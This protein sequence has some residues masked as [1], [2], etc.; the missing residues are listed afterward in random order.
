[1]GTIVVGVDGSDPSFRALRWAV[2]EARL[3]G[4]TVKIVHSWEFP[5]AVKGSDGLPHAD[6]LAS[7]ETVCEQAIAAVEDIASG[8]E[9]TTEIA[10]ELPAEA[11]VRESATAELVVVGSRGRGG[12]GGLL[13]GSVATQVAQ[14]AK[15]PAVIVPHAD[16]L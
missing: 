8:I 6:L 10:P 15:C 4:A 7:A 5:P 12:F 11:L 9:V 13:L 2:E 3:R 1:M 14:H 16:R